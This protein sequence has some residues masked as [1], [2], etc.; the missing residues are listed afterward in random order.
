MSRVSL[1]RRLGAIIEAAERIDPIAARVYRL[2]PALHVRYDNWRAE[3]DRAAAQYPD[4]AAMYEAFLSG[5]YRTPPMPRDV[6]EALGLQP[7]PL[8]PETMTARDIADVWDGMVRG[9]TTPS[10]RTADKFSSR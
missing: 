8:L 9:D 10:K 5:E 3:C 7:A 4:G 6:R 2:P 1:N